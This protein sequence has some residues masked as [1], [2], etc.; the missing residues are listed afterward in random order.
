[1]SAVAISEVPEKRK[2][3]TNLELSWLRFWARLTN[4]GGS[5]GKNGAPKRC[6]QSNWPS[7]DARCVRIGKA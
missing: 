5:E 1:M 6:F 2:L 4:E 3:Y 7:P